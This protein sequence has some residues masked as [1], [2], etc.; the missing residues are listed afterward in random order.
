MSLETNKELVRQF[1]HFINRKDL[2]TAL[3]LLS[4][5]FVAHTP[6]VGLPSGVEGVR[7]FF[8]MF[9]AEFRQDF[10]FRPTRGTLERPGESNLGRNRRVYE[11]VERPE[12]DCLYHLFYI[13]CARSD[14]P[15]H[16]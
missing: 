6:A 8:T 9:S 4:P 3:A 12:T 16:E 15:G 1:E 2:D 5:N 7:A 10:L 13:T 14:V 11:L